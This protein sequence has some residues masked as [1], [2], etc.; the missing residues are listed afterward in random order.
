MRTNSTPISIAMA[1]TPKATT[2]VNR[3]D[4]RKEALAAT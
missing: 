1:E 3:E 2:D 4:R